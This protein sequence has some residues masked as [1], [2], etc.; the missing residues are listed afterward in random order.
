MN[1]C[2]PYIKAMLAGLVFTLPVVAP[3]A[4]PSKTEI[5]SKL[6]P[7]TM[8]AIPTESTKSVQVAVESKEKK[9]I[10]ALYQYKNKKNGTLTLTNRPQKYE[11][12]PE[13][14]QVKISYQRIVI[15][16]KYVAL[17]YSDPSKYT[18]AEVWKLVQQYSGDYGLDPN[19]VMAVIKCESNGNPKAVSPAGAS[20][21]M[22]LMP[23]TALEMGVTNI[24][25]P[26]QNIA[27]GTQYLSKMMELFNN[28]VSLALAGYNAGPENVKKYNGIPPFN[29]TQN[30]VKLVTKR[31]QEFSKGGETFIA[32][33]LS[34]NSPILSDKIADNRIAPIAKPAGKFMI[35]FMGGLSQPADEIEDKDPYYY[36]KVGQ[37]TYPVRKQ[38]VEKV[39]N[40]G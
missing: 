39:E 38:L 5:S 31:Y 23:A 19:L 10:G 11:H 27:G 22:Q 8:S 32:K 1:S 34:Y 26:A 17:E 9:N 16:K 20:G 40:L 33:N 2:R 18:S 12:R 28:N 37:R 15:P 21:L 7:L 6:T 29:E 25:D 30:Y 14:T 24:F 4:E 13:Y 36:I 35:H 3:F